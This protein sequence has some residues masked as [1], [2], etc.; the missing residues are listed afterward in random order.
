MQGRALSELPVSAGFAGL[1]ITAAVDL[2]DR[3]SS[4]SNV[5]VLK[6]HCYMSIFK[7]D[8]L[9]APPHLHSTLQSYL[10][11]QHPGI[12][13]SSYSHVSGFKVAVF[14]LQPGKEN[15]QIWLCRPPSLK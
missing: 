7:L 4:Y 2:I 3:L 1:A 12:R 15:Q 11:A 9:P 6:L 13:L 5:S 8:W 10:P 14:Q